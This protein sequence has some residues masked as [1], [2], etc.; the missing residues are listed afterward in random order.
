MSRNQK[1]VHI[2]PDICPCMRTKTMALNTDY[3]QSAYEHRFTADTAY[4]YCLKTMAV[5]G[6]DELDAMPEICRPG[7][8]CYCGDEPNPT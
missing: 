4:F 5:Q 8:A 7:R 2:P 6:P 1:A 3:R